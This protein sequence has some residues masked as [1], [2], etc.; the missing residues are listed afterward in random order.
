MP[1]KKLNTIFASKEYQ[2]LRGNLSQ[3]HMMIQLHFKG[4]TMHE[5]TLFDDLV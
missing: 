4:M 3:S 1:F 2:T 5:K